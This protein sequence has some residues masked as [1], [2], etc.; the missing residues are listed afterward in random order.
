MPSIDQA[1]SAGSDVM[2]LSRLLPEYARVV[3]SELWP[4]LRVT[5]ADLLQLWLAS[6]G[7]MWFP[8]QASPEPPVPD[9]QFPG[10]ATRWQVWR[11]GLEAL[12]DTVNRDELRY[13][14]GLSREEARASISTFFSRP[15]YG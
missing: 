2:A 7:Q 1:G 12:V 3:A 6:T 14:T 15:P 5:E 4:E 13:R 11:K 10:G 8:G 9:G